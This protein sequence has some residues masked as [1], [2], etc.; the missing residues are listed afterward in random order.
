MTNSINIIIQSL[1]ET[2]KTPI[3]YINS[4]KIK[5]KYNKIK[6]LYPE[7]NILY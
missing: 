7:I 1:L 4:N 2:H 6:D 5:E 3:L